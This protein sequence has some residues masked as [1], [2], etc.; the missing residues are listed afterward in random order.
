LVP[1]G[2][3]PFRSRCEDFLNRR[4]G[5]ERNCCKKRIRGGEGRFLVVAVL[6]RSE[7]YHGAARLRQERDARV[8]R[9]CVPER[10]CDSGGHEEDTKNTQA[11][12]RGEP[13]DLTRGTTRSCV[14]SSFLLFRVRWRTGIRTSDRLSG[15][16][17]DLVRNRPLR[18]CSYQPLPLLSSP[19]IEEALQRERKG[20]FHGIRDLRREPCA[21]SERAGPT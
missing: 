2:G 11:R 1:I 14:Q 6:R 9:R 8:A 21:R 15:T 5:Q 3:C 20:P 16:Q 7:V 17:A 18:P 4:K 12:R 19:L 10:A 13:D